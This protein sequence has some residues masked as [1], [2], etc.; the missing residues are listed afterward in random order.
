MTL[1][2]LCCLLPHH[3]ALSA[4]VSRPQELLRKKNSSHL[5]GLQP[6]PADRFVGENESP[7]GTAD[8]DPSIKA[9]CS[10]ISSL[11]IASVTASTASMLL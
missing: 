3:L 11:M 1:V 9:Y 10:G 5:Q 7:D 4:A 8:T 6:A 2:A